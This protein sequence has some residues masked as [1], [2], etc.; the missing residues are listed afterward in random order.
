MSSTVVL[1]IVVLP[2]VVS[3]AIQYGF[4]DLNADNSGNTEINK[5]TGVSTRNQ[6]NHTDLS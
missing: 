1:S 3:A 4:K 5:R 2:T 6:G